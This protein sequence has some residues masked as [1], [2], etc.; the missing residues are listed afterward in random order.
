ML[1]RIDAFGVAADLVEH[2]EV[3][4][5]GKRK[6]GTIVTITMTPKSQTQASVAPAAGVEY[7]SHSRIPV[8]FHVGY[9]YSK[10]QDVQFTTVRSASQADLF[11]I[12]K[13]NKATQA[14]AAFLSLGKTFEQGQ[15]GV[16]AT[17]G[18]D[19]AKP[20][21]RVYVG[22]SLQLLKKTFITG[23]FVSGTQQE[24]ANKVTDALGAALGARELFATI[25]PQ[26]RWRGFG[27]I[28][29]RVF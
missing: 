21:E 9:V 16:F 4:N 3:H 7:F 26:R 27:A 10:L 11:S 15:V 8:L 24:P 28:S 22:G 5:I 20:G 17:L 12:V 25:D 14:L 13:E 23:G 6:G 1:G 18:T 2:G 29:F 19:F